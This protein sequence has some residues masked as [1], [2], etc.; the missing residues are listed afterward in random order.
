MVKRAVLFINGDLARLP[1]LYLKKSDF[2]IGVDGGTKLILRLKRRPDLVIGDFDSYPKPKAKAL[3]KQSQDLTDTEFALD[4]CVKH[5]FKDIVLVG[6]LGSRLDHL[7]TNI[8]LGYRFNF[9]IIE[10]QQTLYFVTTRIILV[11]K[12][13]DLVSLIPL[14]SDCSGVTTSGLKWRLQ[15]DSLKFGFGRGVSNVMTGK[16]AQ[17]FLKRGC[18]LVIRTAQP[19]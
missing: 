4:Y 12:P 5:G 1:R 9:T 19:E 7:L 8:F 13:G 6:V 15:G 11:G 10:G 17:I 14:L 2:L 18:L 16:I 3:Y